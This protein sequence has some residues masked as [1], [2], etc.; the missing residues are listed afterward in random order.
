MGAKKLRK[1]QIGPE[2]TA[3]TPVAATDRWVGP[4]AGIESLDTI[5]FIEHD[6]GSLLGVDRTLKTAVGAQLTIPECAFNFEQF[7]WFL[8][9]GI[10]AQQTGVADGAGT[11]LIYTHTCPLTAAATVKA[12]TVEAGDG[13]QAHEM[14][15]SFCPSFSLSGEQNAAVKMAGVFRGRQRSDTTFTALSQAAVHFAAANK[16]KLYLDAVAGTMGATAA[17]SMIL[18]WN[19]DWSTGLVPC[20]TEDGQLY[21]TVPAQ[22][23]PEITLK[24]T[25]RHIAGAVTEYGYWLAETPRLLELTIEG[26]ALATAGT[27]YTYFTTRVQLPGKWEKFDV[28]ADRNGYNIV[29]GTFRAR[30]NSTYAVAPRIILVNEKAE[31]WA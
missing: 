19:L 30:E 9:S 3:G 27:D 31:Y 29:A 23:G 16:A 1:I 20:M 22:V 7:A 18:G 12:L 28:L 4:G 24:V 2:A 17:A 10:L 13:Q 21:F 5:E 14:A 25:F 8:Q 6:D 26:A 15:Y 11:G